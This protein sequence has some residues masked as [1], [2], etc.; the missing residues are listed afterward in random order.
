MSRALP[1]NPWAVIL[2]ALHSMEVTAARPLV[3]E[4]ALTMQKIT[5]FLW[6]V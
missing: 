1:V 6:F 3:D 2:A 5:P 4:E